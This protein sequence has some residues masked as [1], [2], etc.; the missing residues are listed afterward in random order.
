VREKDEE[1][2]D[3]SLFNGTWLSGGPQRAVQHNRCVQ[4]PKR[5]PNKCALMSML[6]MM[7]CMR[8]NE[9]YDMMTAGVAT[10]MHLRHCTHPGLYGDPYVCMEEFCYCYCYCYCEGHLSLTFTK[11]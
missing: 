4:G 9:Y 5:G 11:D 6:K 2:D 8:D 3:E 1:K 10:V 7:G